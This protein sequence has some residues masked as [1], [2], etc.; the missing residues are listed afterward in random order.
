MD[1]LG[2]TSLDVA[3][4]GLIQTR[5]T[6][7]L[8]PIAPDAAPV[9]RVYG[10]D[11]GLN[12][13]ATLSLK[14]TGVVTD[15]SNA[16]PIVITSAAHG[17]QVGMRVV[18]ASVGGNTAA[19]GTWT[20]SAVTDDTFTL[21]GST[22]NGSYTSGGTWHVLGL[23]LLTITPTAGNGYSEGVTYNGLVSWAVSSVAQNSLFNFTVV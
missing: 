22:G 9:M 17:L 16:S 6:S 3:I 23:Y 15:A 7:T 2:P 4:T 21:S 11:G 1:Y 19:N 13:T 8:T 20:I 5:N 14:D 12:E 10:D 18:V